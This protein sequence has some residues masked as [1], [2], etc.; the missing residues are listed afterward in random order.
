M[1]KA[2][3]LAG[4]AA[5]LTFLADPVCAQVTARF[6]LDAV[7]DCDKP[8]MLR[9][10]AIHA[11]GTGTLSQDRSATLDVSSNVEGMQRYSGQLGG[12]PIETPDGSASLRVR[13]RRS[14]RAIR[15]YPNNQVIIDV[16]SLGKACTVKIQNRLK[17]GKKQYTFSTSFG[18]AYCSA[19]R[20]IKTTCAV[21]N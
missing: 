15:D 13:S 8:L 4:C 5:A 9:D 10:F 2:L 1:A 21:A 7:A 19:P 18:L 14:L 20:N 16:I 3:L 12:K 17:P 11:E 6:T